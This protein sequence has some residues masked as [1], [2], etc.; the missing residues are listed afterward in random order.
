MVSPDPVCNE[1]VSQDV[2]GA[3]LS[4]HVEYLGERH[5]HSWVSSR[6]VELYGHIEKS[7][8]VVV[9]PVGKKVH[10]FYT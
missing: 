2:D 4:Y 3:V 10:E 9:P 1:S 6:F 8:K 7:N 5:S